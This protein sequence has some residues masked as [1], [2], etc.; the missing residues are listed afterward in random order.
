MHRH[1]TQCRHAFTERDLA[2]EQTRGM[3]A[4]RK[5]LGLRGLTFRYYTC[6]ECG[7]DD[8]FLDLTP[9]AGESAEDYRRRHEE[10]EAVGRKAHA[11]GLAVVVLDKGADGFEIGS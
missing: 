3:E 1:C 2:R 4:D 8:I 6:P 10:L 7:Q 11:D 5:A 9:L